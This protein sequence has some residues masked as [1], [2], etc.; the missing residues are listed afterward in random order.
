MEHRAAN[1]RYIT[2][3]SRIE[4]DAHHEHQTPFEQINIQKSSS[5]IN[6]KK[7]TNTKKTPQQTTENVQVSK[8]QTSS[9]GRE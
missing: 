9:K 7:T 4:T 3:I 6:H 2:R 5:N 8:T 1:Y